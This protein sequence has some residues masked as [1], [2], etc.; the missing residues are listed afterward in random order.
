M[1]LPGGRQ[2][3]PAM[4]YLAADPPV[5]EWSVST[6]VEVGE[7]TIGRIRARRLADGRTELGFLSASGESISP[8]IRFLPADMPD[9]VWLRTSVIQVP[10]AAVLQGEGD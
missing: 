7:G 4:R 6:D 9:G 8:D 2:V 10:R 5:D 1:E 3:L